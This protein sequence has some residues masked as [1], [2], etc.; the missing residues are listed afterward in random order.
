M[1]ALVWAWLWRGY[2]CTYIF[3]LTRGGENGRERLD[4]EEWRGNFVCTH[5]HPCAGAM[6]IFSVFVQLYMILIRRLIP[7][8]QLVFCVH[9]NETAIFPLHHHASLLLNFSLLTFL[10][11]HFL[12]P[13]FKRPLEPCNYSYQ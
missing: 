11:F 6:L 12:P 7:F 8:Q 2:C 13:R 4:V 3:A 9:F 5:C 1:V 10:F